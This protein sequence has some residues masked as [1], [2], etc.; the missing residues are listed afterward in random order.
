MKKD[1]DMNYAVTH[2]ELWANIDEVSKALM[3]QNNPVDTEI[4]LEILD[5]P[6]LHCYQ[7]P[8]GD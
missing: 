6:A 5:V 1:E 7:E 4:K 3:D 2:S 8:V